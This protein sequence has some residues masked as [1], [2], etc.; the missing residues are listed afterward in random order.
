MDPRYIFA[1]FTFVASLA[2]AD[3]PVEVL[4]PDVRQDTIY[5][6]ICEKGY[7][8]SVRPS[9]LYTNGVKRK[10]M[11]EQG[12]DWARAAEMELDHRV[13]LVLGGHPRNIHNLQLQ[14]WDGVNG[15]KAKDKLEKLLA[16]DVCMGKITLADAQKCIW[17]DWMRCVDVLPKIKMPHSSA[18][19]R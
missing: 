16:R 6:T 15:A 2:I 3:V 5:E 13:P 9:S 18:T 4:N 10:L 12:I 7:T 19:T 11:Q 17:N 8:K 14:W 1:L